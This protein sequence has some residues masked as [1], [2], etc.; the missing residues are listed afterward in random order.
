M[1]LHYGCAP[2]V[3]AT[4][5]WGGLSL[6]REKRFT[7]L[8]WLIAAY[9][10]AALLYTPWLLVFLKQLQLAKTADNAWNIPLSIKRFLIILFYPFIGYYSRFYYA[11]PGILLVF[12]C[13]FYRMLQ[14]NHKNHFRLNH[15]IVLLFCLYFSPLAMGFFLFLLTGKPIIIERSMIPGISGMALAFGL[16]FSDSNKSRHKLPFLLICILIS[17]FHLTAI[18]FRTRDDAIYQMREYLQHCVHNSD[19]ELYYTDHFHASVLAEILPRC[20][21]RILQRETLPFWNGKIMRNISFLAEY[22]KRQGR[23]FFIL[24]E[25]T[26]PEDF[27]IE[28]QIPGRLRLQK[29]FISSYRYTG[30]YIYEMD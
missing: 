26:K 5:V 25:H 28:M 29:A 13:V 17:C 6:W 18:F 2:G 14:G 11:I 12:I 19:V 27:V 10:F 7:Q 8:I 23:K 9:L 30:F 20:Q 16:F 21:H 3:A 1:S 24:D 22:P 4:A 15:D